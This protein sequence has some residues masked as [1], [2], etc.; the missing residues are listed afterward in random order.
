MPLLACPDIKD[1]VWLAL[2]KD[3]ARLV[4]F[5]VGVGVSHDGGLKSAAQD[6]I[7]MHEL[8]EDVAHDRG[9]HTATPTGFGCSR[10]NKTSRK[11][12]RIILISSQSDQFS[13]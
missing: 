8:P 5:R 12:R 13:M 2:Q 7:R 1:G 9:F 11:V 4:V 6:R 10:W 3:R